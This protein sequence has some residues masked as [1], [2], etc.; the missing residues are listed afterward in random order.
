[1]TGLRICNAYIKWNI[2]Q[3]QKE[4]N[5]AICSNMDEPRE[6]YAQWIKSDRE[7]QVLYGITYRL[8]LKYNMNEPIYQTETDPQT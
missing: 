1:M 2:T 3:P 8:N 5:I 7:K 6:H 4:W